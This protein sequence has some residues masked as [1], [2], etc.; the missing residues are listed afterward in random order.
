M[1]T[2][3]RFAKAI[4]TYGKKSFNIRNFTYNSHNI[5]S[6]G[7]LVLILSEKKVGDYFLGDIIKRTENKNTK[8]YIS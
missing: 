8:S 3:L 1:M 6:S 5:R 4:R 7:V 2:K